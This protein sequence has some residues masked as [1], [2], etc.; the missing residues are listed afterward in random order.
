[1]V[2]LR[3]YLIHAIVRNLSE[4]LKIS[5]SNDGLAIT[6][7]EALV[8]AIVFII[9]LCETLN[10]FTIISENINVNIKGVNVY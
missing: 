10:F 4:K 2:S 5:L 9:K 1:M 3:R 7:K 6:S 8:L